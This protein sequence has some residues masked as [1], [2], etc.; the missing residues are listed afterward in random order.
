MT[1]PKALGCG[2]LWTVL[3]LAG[4]GWL[5]LSAP[6]TATAQAPTEAL[7]RIVAVVDDEIILL[8]ELEQE[9]HAGAHAA[10]SQPGDC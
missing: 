10:G 2:A 5:G 9:P 6:F 7:D 3:A 8:S 1:G 4:M